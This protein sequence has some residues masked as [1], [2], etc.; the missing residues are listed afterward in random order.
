M[1][2]Y[3]SCNSYSK[4]CSSYFSYYLCSVIDSLLA[5]RDSR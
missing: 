1:K 5:N 3:G 4:V 2:A